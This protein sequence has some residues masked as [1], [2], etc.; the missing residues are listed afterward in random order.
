MACM[1][2]S[3][4]QQEVEQAYQ[5]VLSLL[6]EKYKIQDEPPCCILHCGF[7]AQNMERM[8]EDANNNLKAAIQTLFLNQACEDF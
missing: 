8:R 7:I 4:N 2:P 1:G 5:D 6:K 3:V